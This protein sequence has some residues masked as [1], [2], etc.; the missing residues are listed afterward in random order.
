ML[1]GS[2]SLRP[3]GGEVGRAVG[4]EGD[5]LPSSSIASETAWLRPS[6]VCEQRFQVWAL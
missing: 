4:V 3:P 1:R 5:D 6:R 2:A